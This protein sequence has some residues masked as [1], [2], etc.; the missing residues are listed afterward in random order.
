ML[1]RFRDRKSERKLPG[2][3]EGSGKIVTL[4]GGAVILKQLIPIAV[5]MLMTCTSFAQDEG[6]I[7]SCSDCHGGN[8]TDVPA[9]TAEIINESQ[10]SPIP[11][12]LFLAGLSFA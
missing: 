5:I 12:A 3:Y 4:S 8:K 7:E 6:K 11:F 1:I 10:P 9:V 2:G